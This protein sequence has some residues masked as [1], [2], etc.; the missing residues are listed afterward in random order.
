M[1]RRP[2]ITEQMKAP[3]GAFFVFALF[4]RYLFFAHPIDP[5]LGVYNNQFKP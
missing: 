2:A 4:A 5:S 3:C 1:V